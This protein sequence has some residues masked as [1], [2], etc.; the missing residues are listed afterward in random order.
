V[1][2]W[3]L[4]MLFTYWNWEYLI[5]YWNWPS[6]KLSATIEAGCYTP[7]WQLFSPTLT[8]IMPIRSS[9][10]EIQ[11]SLFSLWCQNH[12][13]DNAEIIVGSQKE[14]IVTCQIIC[15]SIEIFEIG[16][17]SL[18]INQEAWA[19]IVR[20]GEG[21]G[22]TQLVQNGL[23]ILIW[24]DTYGGVREL[25]LTLRNFLEAALIEGDHSNL[26]PLTCLSFSVTVNF[27]TFF[28]KCFLTNHGITLAIFFWAWKKKTF[29]R[30]ETKFAVN[31]IT[32]Q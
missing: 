20:G 26:M 15:S 4:R 31:K 10:R 6:V 14:H 29:W 28:E 11:K 1:S 18:Q 27:F 22:R 16:R 17:R 19:G 5:T 9:F 30:N 7:L 13:C 32:Q 12:T 23:R 3:L 8:Y 21:R 24:S 25:C 2:S